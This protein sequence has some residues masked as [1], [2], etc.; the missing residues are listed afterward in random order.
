MSI[1]GLIN[2]VNQFTQT[3]GTIQGAADAIV[4]AFYAVDQAMSQVASVFTGD[5]YQQPYPYHPAPI[6]AGAGPSSGLVGSLLAGGVVGAITHKQTAD[7]LRSF[8]SGI[9][10][11]LKN[12]GLSSLKSGAIGAGVMGAVSGIQ[13]FAAA[14]R[15]EITK[16]AAG[17]NVAADTVGGLLAGVGGGLAAGTASMAL[18]SFMPGGGILMTIGAAAAGALGATGA[19]FLYQSSGARDS[20]ANSVRSAMGEDT[21]QAYQGY[22]AAPQSYYQYGY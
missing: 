13:N 11:G 15:G 20:I 6:P 5:T 10:T 22:Y 16:A 17:G 8:K 19:N 1:D 2:N 4:P 12:L 9:G 14:S 3:A 18:G 7:A 21:V